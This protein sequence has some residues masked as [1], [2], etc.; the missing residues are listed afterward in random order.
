VL[1]GIEPSYLVLQTS[2][3]PSGSSTYIWLTR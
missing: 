1:Q 2:A 3:S